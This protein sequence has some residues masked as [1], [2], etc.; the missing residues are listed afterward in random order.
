MAYVSR[1]TSQHSPILIGFYHEIGKLGREMWP[2]RPSKESP[3]AGVAM[4]GSVSV[5]GFDSSPFQLIS[6]PGG[7][8]RGYSPIFR[9]I[10]LSPRFFLLFA[11][12]PGVVYG[13]FQVNIVATCRELTYPDYTQTHTYTQTLHPF[14]SHLLQGPWHPFV[15][16]PW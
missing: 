13:L 15:Y 2:D 11:Y 16:E 8:V 14:C 9:G 5:R 1:S 4:S 12:S 10:P 7:S 3:G 6:G